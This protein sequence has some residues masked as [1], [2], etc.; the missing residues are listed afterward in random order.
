MFIDFIFINPVLFPSIID[1]PLVAPAVRLPQV[2]VPALSV[3]FEVIVFPVI[4]PQVVLPAV[5]TPQ[6]NGEVVVEVPIFPLESIVKKLTLPDAGFLIFVAAT[7]I[8]PLAF[9]NEIDC[10][11]VDPA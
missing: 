9:P 6:V 2:V 5:R 7:F 8:V 4:F 3:P 1:W 10:P 11:A